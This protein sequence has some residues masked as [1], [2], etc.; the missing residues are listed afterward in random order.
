MSQAK[1]KFAEMGSV[2][3]TRSS[4]VFLVEVPDEIWSMDVI[5]VCPCVLLI[6]VAFP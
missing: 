4:G 3:V 5:F 1:R 2:N 6:A